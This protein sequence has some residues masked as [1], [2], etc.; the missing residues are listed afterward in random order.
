MLVRLAGVTPLR[1]TALR[2]GHPERV[3]DDRPSGPVS[4]HWLG[5]AVDVNSLGGVP[6]A[7]SP[8]SVVRGVVEAAAA[9]PAV[10][11]VGAPPGMDL[12]GPGRRTFTNLVHADHLHVAVEVQ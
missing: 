5:R 9:L 11:Q 8:A 12:D 1:V 6:V 2:T 4:A 7:E 10:D 3:V